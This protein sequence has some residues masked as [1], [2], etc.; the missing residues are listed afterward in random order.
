MP[1]NKAAQNPKVTY[2]GEPTFT[3]IWIWNWRIWNWRIMGLVHGGG[4]GDCGCD[5]IAEG[6]NR[7]QAGVEQY[8]VAYPNGDSG[9]GLLPGI[10]LSTEPYT[11][12]KPA[13]WGYCRRLSDTR[14]L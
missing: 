10:T 11:A 3:W 14:L 9:Q 13:S 4:G 6:E 5:I 2:N 12:G 8:A 1:T 7:L